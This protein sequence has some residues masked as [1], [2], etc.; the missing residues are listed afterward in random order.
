MVP[1]NGYF[2]RRGEETLAWSAP[3]REQI[4]ASGDGKDAGDK[5]PPGADRVCA[6]LHYDARLRQVPFHP[7]Y[8]AC[9]LSNTHVDPAAVGSDGGAVRL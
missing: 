1:G 2:R 9:Y 6:L 3:P 5:P 7:V 8:D 4:D